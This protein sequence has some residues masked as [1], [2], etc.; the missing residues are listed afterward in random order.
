[1]SCPFWTCEMKSCYLRRTLI[2]MRHGLVLQ[3]NKGVNLKTC[4]LTLALAW[5]PLQLQ[6]V[7]SPQ[8]TGIHALSMGQSYIMKHKCLLSIGSG[9][10]TQAVCYVVYVVFADLIQVDPHVSKSGL[11]NH[12]P[13]T[14]QESRLIWSFRKWSPKWFWVMKATHTN[15]PRDTYLFWGRWAKLISRHYPS[16]QSHQDSCLLNAQEHL[17]TFE[18]QLEQLKKQTRCGRKFIGAGWCWLVLDA[19]GCSNK[20][21]PSFA[22][23]LLHFRYVLNVSQMTHKLVSFQCLWEQQPGVL[24][25]TIIVS[26]L[27]QT[28]CF[29]QHVLIS[30]IAIWKHRRIYCDLH[31][32]RNATDDGW[33]DSHDFFLQFTA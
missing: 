15:R 22:P 11:K 31:L 24:R 8:K 29:R 19:Y 33:L 5:R 2:L 26:I 13:L 25:I 18:E 12:L 3:E 32:L 17:L 20:I 10:Y 21:T 1:M 27:L 28:S 30:L 4:P 7:K 6:R 9:K 23:F 16:S 14:A